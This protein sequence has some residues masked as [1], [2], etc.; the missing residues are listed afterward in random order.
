VEL[1]EKMKQQFLE[2]KVG[3]LRLTVYQDNRP[4]VP[5]SAQI[6]L[7]T[8]GGSVLQAIVAV[9]AIDSTTGEMTYSLTATHTALADLN[10]KAV[11]E[12]VVS[13]VTYYENQL[14]DVVKSILSI[15][16]TD[17]DLYG[18]LESLRKTNIQGKGTATSSGTAT[19]FADTKRKEEDN[20]W[21]GGSVEI[22]G[23]VGSGQNGTITSFVQSTGVFNFV[24]SW[25]FTLDTTS[26]YR[27]V[28]SFS[29][30]IKQCFEKLEDMLY[31][32]G[33]R[34]DLILESSQIKFPLIYLVIHFICL[35]LMDEQND[36]WDRLSIAYW[37]KFQTAFNNLKLEYDEDESGN[38]EGGDEEGSQPSSLR[39]QRC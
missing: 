7:Y 25:A 16:I 4:V 5:S 10:Y 15:P 20:Y 2:D 3:T 33:K 21:K 1:E 30:K 34:Q 27:V 11:W 35:D 32:K 39:I 22:L 13:G 28:K 26:T 9:S 37:D 19:T 36:K 24:P 6:T 8:S 17:D 12:Y 18:E 23:G 31:S 29:G 38:I 14:F